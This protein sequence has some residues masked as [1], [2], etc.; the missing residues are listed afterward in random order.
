MGFGTPS[1]GGV[2]HRRRLSTDPPASGSRAPQGLAASAGGGRRVVTSRAAASD[3]ALGGAGTACARF[4]A[5]PHDRNRRVEWRGS[6]SA[7]NTV[8]TLRQR[9]EAALGRWACRGSNRYRPLGRTGHNSVG[10]SPVLLESGLAA[11][12]TCPG[13]RRR[14]RPEPAPGLIGGQAAAHNHHS[15][16]LA[17]STPGAQGVILT[18]HSPGLAFPRAMHAGPPAGPGKSRVSMAPTPRPG[19]PKPCRMGRR[20]LQAAGLT[21]AARW[22]RLTLAPRR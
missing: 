10:H 5:Q 21:R 14:R 13:P 20:H 6:T 12:I 8:A 2:M 15:G 11:R 9:E 4:I 22:H 3:D 16:R 19:N 1:R 18:N 17:S 7:D